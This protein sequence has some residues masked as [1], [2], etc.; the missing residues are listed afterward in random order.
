MKNLDKLKN[1]LNLYLFVNRN[2]K[3]LWALKESF[4]FILRFFYASQQKGLTKNFAE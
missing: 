4:F 3:A 1:L 2:Q